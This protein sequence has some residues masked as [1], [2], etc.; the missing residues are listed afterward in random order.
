[1]RKRDAF[2]PPPVEPAIAPTHITSRRTI[3]ENSDHC[4][5]SAVINPVVEDT[6]VTANA[7]YRS[8]VKKS[9]P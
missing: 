5:K 3:C 8:E 1:M 9:F 2:K 4:A 6:E 7:E